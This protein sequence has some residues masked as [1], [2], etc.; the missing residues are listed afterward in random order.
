MSDTDCDIWKDSSQSWGSLQEEGDEH[1]T[2]T[3]SQ[4]LFL[5]R[6]KNKNL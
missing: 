1:F 6:K 3:M 4:P 5:Y 2:F